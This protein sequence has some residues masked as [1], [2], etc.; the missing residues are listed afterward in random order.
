MLAQQVG[1]R[2]VATQ[3]GRSYKATPHYPRFDIR[4]RCIF[5]CCQYTTRDSCSR[6]IRETLCPSVA[7]CSVSVALPLLLSASRAKKSVKLTGGTGIFLPV[8]LAHSLD[9]SLCKT[10]MM[11]TAWLACIKKLLALEVGLRP[12]SLGEK[13]PTSSSLLFNQSA[14]HEPRRVSTVL[15]AATT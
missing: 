7:I 4:R 12:V 3:V 1:L 8:S 13:T 10:G 6:G 11:N 2:A 15:S 14:G 5:R 9:R